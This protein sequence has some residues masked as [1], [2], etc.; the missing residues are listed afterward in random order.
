MGR[1]THPSPSLSAWQSGCLT[2]Q[3]LRSRPSL[4]PSPALFLPCQIPMVPLTPA[5]SILLNICL[6]LKLSYLTWVRVSIWLLIGEWGIRL[7]ALGGPQEGK[8]GEQGWDLPLSLPQLLQDSPC[9]SA[10][11][12]GT[13]NRT[14]RSHQS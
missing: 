8:E 1:P 10:M 4:Q 3:A 5:L 2:N 6:M 9:I 11:A 7:G 13:A 12:S 14:G